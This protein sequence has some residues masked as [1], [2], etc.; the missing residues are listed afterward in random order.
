MPF[1]YDYFKSCAQDLG[2]HQQPIS[3]NDGYS[4]KIKKILNGNIRFFSS[5]NYLHNEKTQMALKNNFDSR[6]CDI[7]QT[8]RRSFRD[9]RVLQKHMVYSDIVIYRHF[10]FQ[11]LAG[12]PEYTYFFVYF[13][14]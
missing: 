10:A 13:C 9:P 11:W 8:Q 3:H 6:N 12:L 2:K 4:D 5:Q 1:G 14:V 7:K